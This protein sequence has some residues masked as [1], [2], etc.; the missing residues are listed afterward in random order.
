[1]PRAGASR[2]MG[3]K[4]SWPVAAVSMIALVA[5]VVTSVWFAEGLRRAAG[6]DPMFGPAMDL[7]MI[8]GSIAGAAIIGFTALAEARRKPPPPEFFPPALLPQWREVEQPATPGWDP[9]ERR[10]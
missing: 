9:R 2:A 5:G 1:M 4:F 8:G 7:W 6:A 3:G 10:W